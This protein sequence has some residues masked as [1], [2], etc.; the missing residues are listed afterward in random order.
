[1]KITESELIE[2][3]NDPKNNIDMGQCDTNAIKVFVKFGCDIHSGEATYME[4]SGEKHDCL[5]IWNVLKFTSESGKEE[6]QIIDIINYKK[7][8][9]G[10]YTAH[11][12]GCLVSK[13]HLERTRKIKREL[14]NA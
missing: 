13:E 4:C 14:L 5:H 10:K 3:A 1:M 11:R 6:T 12:D 2:F 9:G 7:N 8:M